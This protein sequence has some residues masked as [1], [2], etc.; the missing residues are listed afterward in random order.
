MSKYKS[1]P[2]TYTASKEATKSASPFKY[3][4]NKF[5]ANTG[6]MISQNQE[7]FTEGMEAGEK[8]GKE[9]Q[10][11]KDTVDPKQCGDGH[12]W[13]EEQGKCIPSDGE[14]MN[15]ETTGDTNSVD[16]EV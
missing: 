11:N 1:T 6:N 4:V 12:M 13:S 16:L 3:Y 7:K 9:L 2:I 8:M 5:A 14:T 15:V 10:S